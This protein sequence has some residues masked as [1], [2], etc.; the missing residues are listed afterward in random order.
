MKRKI[1]ATL[2]YLALCILLLGTMIAAGNTDFYY[3]LP[4]ISRDVTVVN[5]QTKT[6]NT[7]GSYITMN[8]AVSDRDSVEVWTDIR[9]Q[10]SGSTVQYSPRI[11]IST[12]N[13]NPVWI[14]AF[15]EYTGRSGDEVRLR[16]RDYVWG[17]DY[18]AGN[19]DY[20]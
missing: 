12:R 5:F 19:W 6:T 20:R 2:G 1:C 3:Q 14:G 4:I 13:S 15:V 18:V 8:T 9:F 17:S 10:N 16:M 11:T 7:N